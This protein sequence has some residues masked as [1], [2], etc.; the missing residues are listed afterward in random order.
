ML[1]LQK[2][3]LWLRQISCS[4]LWQTQPQ[5]LQIQL[6]LA[7]CYFLLHLSWT[8]SSSGIAGFNRP[9]VHYSQICCSGCSIG[10]FSLQRINLA[11]TCKLPCTLT[12][13]TKKSLQLQVFSFFEHFSTYF[14]IQRFILQSKRNQ[15][16]LHILSEA[17]SG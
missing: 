14:R 12:F 16:P 10:T 13:T 11:Q 4:V 1:Q 8:I 2:M 17:G 3:H 6:S 15:Q 7:S 9:S 5:R